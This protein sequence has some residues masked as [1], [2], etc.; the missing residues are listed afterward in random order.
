MEEIAFFYATK[1]KC[2]NLGDFLYFFDIRF[3]PLFFLF[4]MILPTSGC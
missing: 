3:G 1:D 2:L 4:L